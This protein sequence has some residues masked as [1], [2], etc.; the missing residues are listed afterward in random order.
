MEGF[1]L[2]SYVVLWIVVVFLAIATLSLLR[3]VGQLQMRLGPAGA[4]LTDHGLGIGERFGDVLDP[5]G[6][7]GLDGH[8][9]YPRET[10]SLL[11][12]VS[13]NCKACDEL[14]KAVPT[15]KRRYGGDLDVVLISNSSDTEGNE[16]I[17]RLA[18]RA[19][20]PFVASVPLAMAASVRTTPLGIWLDPQGVVQA[21]GIVNHMEHLESLRNARQSGFASLDHF[22]DSVNEPEAESELTPRKEA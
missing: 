2:I 8:F 6:T 5:A 4:A 22:I 16:G 13:P 3:L 20:L 11:L 14:L 19:R 12:F 1:W 7:P 18:H 17:S 9:D 15:F 21:K 10:D